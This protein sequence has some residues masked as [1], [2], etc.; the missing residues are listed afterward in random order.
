MLSSS[1]FTPPRKFP[2]SLFQAPNS[3]VVR[4]VTLAIMP[5]SRRTQKQCWT[6]SCDSMSGFQLGSIDS[7][8][9]PDHERRARRPHRERLKARDMEC[10]KGCPSY[11]GHR[12]SERGQGYAPSK[13]FRHEK[14]IAA[15]VLRVCARNEI[16]AAQRPE[17][18]V[19]SRL[20]GSIVGRESTSRRHS[21]NTAS[22]KVTELIDLLSRVASKAH[23]CCSFRRQKWGI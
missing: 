6:L 20:G 23:K 7:D 11:D 10:F 5:G 8:S 22:Y 15:P 17:A 1:L 9:L 2:A 21:G 19:P 3:L 13:K 12:S 4:P 18:I 14:E 16:F